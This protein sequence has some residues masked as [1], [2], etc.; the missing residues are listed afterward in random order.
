[1]ARFSEPGQCQRTKEQED[2]ILAAD[3]E[4]EEPVVATNGDA[5]V[6]RAKVSTPSLEF[7][8]TWHVQNR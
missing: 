6:N 5:T 2:A 1:M 3:R 7:R 4:H 8:I